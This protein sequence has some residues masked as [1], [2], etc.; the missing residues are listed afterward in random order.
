MAGCYAISAIDSFQNESSI[1]NRFCIDECSYY[2]LP[3]VFSPNGDNINDL[4][5]PLPYM[6]VEKIDMKIYNRWGNLVF[7]TEDP[8]INWDGTNIESNNKVP[9]GVYYYICDVY[10]HRLSGLE[11][12][13]LVGFIHIF[14]GSEQVINE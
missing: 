8:D 10:T 9:D 7:K 1:D 11:H 13:T 2:D 5:I 12:N 3:N 4:Y 14:T 6:F